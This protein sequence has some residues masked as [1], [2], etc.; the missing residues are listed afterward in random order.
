MTKLRQNFRIFRGRSF[1]RKVLKIRILC[2]KSEGLQ[3]QYPATPPLTKL[4][5]YDTHAFSTTGLDGF[6][7]LYLKRGCPRC[8]FLDGNSNFVATETHEFV[9]SLGVEW[10][11]NSPLTPW[12]GGFFERLVKSTKSLLKKELYHFKL[13]YNELQTIL[14]EVEGILHNRPLIYYYADNNETC[15]TPNHFLFRRVLTSFDLE[16]SKTLIAPVDLTSQTNKLNNI[17]IV[18]TKRSGGL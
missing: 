10:K 3:Y 18:R 14:F 12:H 9:N 5:L 11:I 7:P 8:V 4:R 13:N 1:V 6:G 15:I 2:R 16:K 17:S